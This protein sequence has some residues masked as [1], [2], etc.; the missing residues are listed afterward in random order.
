MAIELIEGEFDGILFDCDGTLVDTAPAHYAALQKIF[1]G[2]GFSMDRDWYYERTGLSPDDLLTTF[3]ALIGKP[4]PESREA[5]REAYIKAY[6][7]GMTHMEEV[8]LIAAIARQWKGK[9]PMAVASNGQC[10]IVRETLRGAGLL[11]LFDKIVSIED[12]KHG[13]PAP[14]IYLEAARR[15]GVPVERCVVL[16]DTDE[17]L[18]S[19]KAAGARCIDIRLH[20]TPS[21]RKA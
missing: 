13:K 21:W 11:E 12:V 8:P 19:A 16:E 5:F 7:G 17:G 18:A 9:V 14:D 15:I 6:L 2:Y 20:W 3:E 10:H 1:S 4:L